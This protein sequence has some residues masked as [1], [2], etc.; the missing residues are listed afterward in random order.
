MLWVTSQTRPDL[1]FETCMISNTG[2]NPKVSLLC[3]AN[4]ALSKLKKDRVCLHFPSLGDYRKLSVIVYCDATH[5]SMADGSSH[6]G[7]I[8]FLKGANGM[9]VPISWQSKRLVRVTKSPMASETLSLG[10]GADSGFLVSSLVCEIFNLP[11]LPPVICYTDNKS[12]M[13]TL[14]TTYVITDRRLRV[15]VARLREMIAEKEIIVC[16]VE[17][18]Q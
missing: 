5:V 9:V 16:W 1:S 15:D 17:G 18:K 12:L 7:H 14:E 8:V 10:E 6:G 13:D 2:K 4:K 3:E 11:V